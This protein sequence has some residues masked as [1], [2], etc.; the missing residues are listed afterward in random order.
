[1]NRLLHVASLNQKYLAYESEQ[2][3][4]RKWKYRFRIGL[5]IGGKCGDIQTVWGLSNCG[6]PI[7]EIHTEHRTEHRT[8]CLRCLGLIWHLWPRKGLFVCFK[9]RGIFPQSYWDANCGW[10]TTKLVPTPVAKRDL[11]FSVKSERPVVL[12]STCK[13]RAFGEEAIT[14]YVCMFTA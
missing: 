14:T 2:S 5:W 3:D 7:S 8:M 11:L 4:P 9:S 6:S 1:M 10:C 13:C 12:T